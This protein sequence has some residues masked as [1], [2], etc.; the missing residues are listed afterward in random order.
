MARLCFAL[1]CAAM[2]FLASTASSHEPNNRAPWQG[3]FVIHYVAT[4][5]HAKPIK[6]YAHFDRAVDDAESYDDCMRA[7]YGAIMAI[8]KQR[9]PHALKI[10]YTSAAG[11]CWRGEK[12]REPLSW[13]SF[14]EGTPWS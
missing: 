11:E 12:P 9:N 1:V 6:S 4:F 3:K 10:V 14:S 7:A 13:K 2:A 5:S 8:A